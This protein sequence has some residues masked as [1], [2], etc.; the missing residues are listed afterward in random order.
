[1]LR[2]VH[3]KLVMIMVLL[4]LSLMT[5]VGTFLIN[6][7]MAFYLEE[8]YT[9][10]SRVFDQNQA[11]SR[12]LE[13]EV[14]SDEDG[15]QAI[16]SIMEAY[17]GDLGLDSRS[18][19]LYILDG[20]T[21]DYLT[22][23]DEEEG[24]GLEY[25]SPNLTRALVEREEGTE[26]NI[27]A[28]YMDVALPITRGDNQ[29]VI[30]ILDNKATVNSLISQIFG[31]ILE[32]LVFG[33]II[34]ILLSF[35]LS[36]TMIIPIQR[37]TEGAMRVA[38]G[39]FSRRIEVTSRDEIG[40]LTDTF[41]DMARQLR[42]TLRQVENER[43]KLDTLFL[44][45][46]DGVVAF[47]RD[48]Q[49]IHSNP[50]AEGMLGRPIGPDTTYKE[51][52]GDQYS[53]EEAMA[54]PDHLEGEVRV[55]DQVLDLLLAPFDRERQGGVLVVLHDVTEER[56]N[57][58]MQREFVANVSHELRTPLTNIRSYAETLSDSAGDI[59]PAMEKKF[60]GVILNESDRMTHIVQDLLTLSRFDSGRDELKLSWFS[61]EGAVQDLYNAVYM[62]AQRHSHTMK[63]CV[64]PGLPQVRADRERIM[65]VMMN[66]VSNSIKYTPD[67]GQIQISAGQNG[68]RVWMQVDDNGIGIPTADRPRIFERFY[69]VDKAR[70]RQSGGTGL[71]LSIA[72][73]IV[74]RHEGALELVDRN[75]PGLSVRMELNIEGPSHDERK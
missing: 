69:R 60:L 45:M 54:A 53:L 44:H 20:E 46:T 68:S 64:E 58:E 52:F 66:I 37:L 61:F 22:G 57:Q 12:N 63:L 49:V 34:S 10:M 26:A 30:Y 73:E 67:G 11:L 47:D 72:K 62:E 27:A 43:N 42:D 75:G 59:P 17:Y 24:R 56:K 21:G 6:S 65:Q 23:T 14:T 41:N 51:L 5:V 2:S 3:M 33:L 48:G 29:Y 25:D 50:A 55:G 71:G 32:S 35:L 8:F 1:M 18:R 9:Q 13:T 16:L 40:V 36:K 7:V 70:S 19:T 4:I 28:D 74:D 39:D 15:A 38:E 31:L